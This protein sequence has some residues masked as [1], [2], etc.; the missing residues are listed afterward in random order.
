MTRTEHLKRIKT[1]KPEPK[2]KLI[3]DFSLEA[4]TEETYSYVKQDTTLNAL[5]RVSSKSEVEKEI[6]L[7]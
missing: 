7:T 1:I 6:L 4:N 3:L 5:A 2:Q